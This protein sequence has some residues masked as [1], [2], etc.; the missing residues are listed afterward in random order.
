MREPRRHSQEQQICDNEVPAALLL[1]REIFG[2]KARPL[3]VL[4]KRWMIDAH[5][6]HTRGRAGWDWPGQRTLKGIMWWLRER[7]PN[8]ESNRCAMHCLTRPPAKASC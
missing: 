5:R 4:R 6:V 7:T 8:G 1:E 2:A 3:L